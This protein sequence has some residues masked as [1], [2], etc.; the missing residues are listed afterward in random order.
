MEAIEH[1]DDVT[2]SIDRASEHIMQVDTDIVS[3]LMLN[4]MEQ[5]I[6]ELEMSHEFLD[7]ESNL[8]WYFSIYTD[9]EINDILDEIEDAVIMAEHKLQDVDAQIQEIEASEAE[10]INYLYLFHTEFV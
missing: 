8:I 4:D 1:P 6:E 10:V 9:G 3:D 2:C 7:F 5:S